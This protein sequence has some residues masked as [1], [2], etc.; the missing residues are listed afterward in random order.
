M[1]LLGAGAPLLSNT[2]QGVVLEDLHTALAGIGRG[3][4]ADAVLHEFLLAAS[5]LISATGRALDLSAPGGRA[6]RWTTALLR[7][8]GELLKAGTRLP[9]LF[10]ELTELEGALARDPELFDAVEG[11]L[12]AGRLVPV[13]HGGGDRYV[14]PGCRRKGRERGALAC[15]GVVALNLPRLARVAGSWREER[16]LEQIVDLLRKSVRALANLNRFQSKLGEAGPVHL[17]SRTQY[18]ITPVGLLQALRILGDGELRADQGARVLGLMA[19]AAARFG[20]EENLDVRLDS[21]FGVRASA[22]FARTDGKADHSHQGRLFSDLPAPEGERVA[23]YSLGFGGGAT[24]LGDHAR[25][26][27]STLGRQAH[28]EPSQAAADFLARLLV[29]VRSGALNPVQNPISG[30]VDGDGAT[31]R[32]HLALWRRFDSMRS[33]HLEH[34]PLSSS[35]PAPA[36]TD[37][38]LFGTLG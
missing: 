22:R 18:S 3:A 12:G 36:P 26:L 20:R 25:A 13:W 37:R 35:T 27:T 5:A 9:R 21:A 1:E 28:M 4:R 8:S 19:E 24:G 14:G 6:E 30:P 10:L 33:E 32:P 16:F 11:L 31:V 34:S 2:S 29:G 38:S 23:H 17:K 15:G 7:Q